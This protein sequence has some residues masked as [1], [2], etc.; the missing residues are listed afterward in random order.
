MNM[1]ARRKDGRLRS[2]IQSPMVAI[3]DYLADPQLVDDGISRKSWNLLMN[4]STLPI[5]VAGGRVHQLHTEG[6][7]GSPTQ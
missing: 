4:T 3:I 5:Y 1:L 2:V 6:G 7:T